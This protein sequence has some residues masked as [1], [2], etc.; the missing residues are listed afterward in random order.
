MRI[1]ILT[2]LLGGALLAAHDVKAQAYG[3]VV[4]NE[5]MPWPSASCGTT[6]EFIE[7]LNFGPGPT[8][9][10]CYILTNGKYSV[11]IPPNTIIQP[12][13]FFVIAGQGSLPI[14]GIGSRPRPSSPKGRPSSRCAAPGTTC[15]ARGAAP[16]P[17][18]RRSRSFVAG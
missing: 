13:Q 6:S 12:G 11:T 5:Y 15:A 4:I 1:C 18:Y 9:I 2:L 17:T 3:R 14:G 7:L 10:G 16:D 8:N